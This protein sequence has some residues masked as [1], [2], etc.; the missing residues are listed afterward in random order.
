VQLAVGCGIVA[1]RAAAVTRGATR[2]K[3]ARWSRAA[4]LSAPLV[5]PATLLAIC[6]V[7]AFGGWP[8]PSVTLLALAGAPAAAGAALLLISGRLEGRGRWHMA[9]LVTRAGGQLAG[10]GC[11]AAIAS[12]VGVTALGLAAPS[13]LGMG[14][15]AVAWSAAGTVALLTG[16]SAKPRPGGGFAALTY[17]A[18]WLAL[19]LV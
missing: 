16:L 3:R 11:A 2:R 6:G 15:A 19:T 18:G 5:L 1:F 9:R 13:R 17:A 8:A 10:W 12:L 14:V 4:R 7:A